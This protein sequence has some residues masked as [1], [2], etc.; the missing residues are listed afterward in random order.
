MKMGMLAYHGRAFMFGVML[1][2]C[3]DSREGQALE[4]LDAKEDVQ[5]FDLGE[6]VVNAERSGPETP[7]TITVVTADEIERKNGRNLGEALNLL[8]GVVFRQSRSKNEF[9]LTVRGFEQDNV[10]ILMDGVPVYQPYEGLVNLADIPTQNIA[11]IKVIKGNAST[12][13]GPGALG[14]VI[15][16]ITRKGTTRPTLSLEYQGS[17]YATHQVQASHGWKVGKLSYYLTGSY[18]TSGGYS[19]SKTFQLPPDVLASMAAAPTNP[20]SLRNTPI[21]ADSGKRDNSDYERKAITFTGTYELT[22]DDKLGLSL[23]YYDNEYGIPPGPVYRETRRG[24]FY[25]PRYW[26]FNDFKRYTVNTTWE[27]KVGNTLRLKGRVFYDGFNSTLDAYD[28]DTYSTQNRI[29]GPPSG[30]S[31]YRD[32]TIGGNLYAFWTGISR[33]ELRFGV[34]AK[35]DV[36]RENFLD[37]AYD[38][39]VSDT[40][41]ISLEDEFRVSDRLKIVAGASNDI[42]AKV[43]REQVAYPGAAAGNNVYSFNPQIGFSY[44]YSPSMR[45]YGSIARKTRF[46]TMRNLYSTGVIGPLGDPDLKE[47][48]SINYELG[49]SWAISEKVFFDTAFFYSDITDLINFDNQIGRFE[50]FHDAYMYGFEAS[51]SCQLNRNL[52]GRIGYTFLQAR[53]R[54]PVTISTDTHGTLVYTPTDLP[55]RPAHK[56]DFEF[57]QDFDFGTKVTFSGSYV[58]SRPYYN[59][60]DTANNSVLVAKREKLGGYL[61]T[62]LKISQD[63]TRHIRIFLSAENLLNE[64]YEDLYQFPSPGR[65]FWVGMKLSI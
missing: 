12:L 4:P 33:Q 24:F 42:F 57:R 31:K 18:K 23:E 49:S 1:L 29:G 13:Y 61:L 45:L 39:L 35:R 62:N 9:Y 65:T 48:R 54:S 50:Q 11:E 27:S 59:H 47:E 36:H 34:S 2:L 15:N 30:K 51:I 19:L 7:S 5:A 56:I 21:P 10:L 41:S 40:Y 22:S 20:A 17:D 53:N 8:P 63:I 14:G 25:F 37:S 46:P 16:I 43:K 28:D 3:L 58:S 52:F 64:D 38:R 6:V 55:Y 44:D 32:Y 26:R 60:A